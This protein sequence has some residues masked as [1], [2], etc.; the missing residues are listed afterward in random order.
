MDGFGKVKGWIDASEPGSGNW[1]KY[2]RSSQDPLQQNV[3][4]VQVQ[5]QVGN[6]YYSLHVNI[7]I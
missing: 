6:Y 7:I 4:A 2:V 1:L 3:M 5:D